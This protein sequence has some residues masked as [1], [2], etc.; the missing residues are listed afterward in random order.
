MEV[1]DSEERNGEDSWSAGG[2]NKALITSGQVLYRRLGGGSAYLLSMDKIGF[3]NVRGMNKSGKLCDVLW[4]LRHHNMGLFGLLETKVKVKIF[5]KV[6]ENF[7][8]EW[9]VITNHPVSN[10]S[11]V[12]IVWLPSIFTI[13]SCKVDVQFVHVCVTHNALRRKFWLTMVYGLNT[14]KE[15][16][17]WFSVY[18]EGSRA[19]RHCLRSNNLTDFNVGGMFYTWTNKQEGEDR[20]CSKIDRVIVNNGWLNNFPSFA[21]E[22]LPEGLMNHS[23]CCMRL[24]SQAGNV[25]KPFRFFN[26]WTEAPNFLAIVEDQKLNSDPTSVDLRKKEH[27]AR[28]AYNE[29]HIARFLFLKQKAKAH[30]MKEGDVNSSYFHACIR[31]RRIE[32]RICSIQDQNGKLVNDPNEIAESFISYYKGL[33][34]TDAGEARQIHQSVIQEG[35]VLSETQRNSICRPFT[36]DDV[37]GA[38]WCIDEDK[39]PGPNGYTSKFFKRSWEIVKG[40][41]CQAVL[42]FFYHGKLL[43]QV[44]TTSLTLIPKVANVVAVT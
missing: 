29:A 38:V 31:Q 10:S 1:P 21:A 6:F 37:R 39:S 12:W 8:R 14:A 34:G 24:D 33:L 2:N 13:S 32:N 16:E 30:W 9:S 42:S 28:L 11:R 22:F 43:K 41:V 40:D 4:I 44:N 27:E 19:F 26:M 17:D 5:G 20:V 3:W 7:G 35:P 23:P 18:F 25:K 15:R 36:E